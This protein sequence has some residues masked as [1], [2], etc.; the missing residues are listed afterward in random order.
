MDRRGN[1]HDWTAPLPPDLRA[2][3]DLPKLKTQHKSWF[4]FVENKEKKKKLEFQVTGGR[5]SFPQTT[6]KLTIVW[7]I[8]TD[9]EP[10]P[11]FE[12][13]PVGNPSLTTACKEISRERG[14]MIFIVTVC[15]QD[16]GPCPYLA[17]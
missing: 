5:A 17:S 12:F 11:G 15:S 9:R 8:T 14:A 7:Q 16:L 6:Q 2:R 1:L 13:V 10:P 4:E 3:R